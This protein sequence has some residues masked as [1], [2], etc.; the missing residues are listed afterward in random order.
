M[1]S[2]ISRRQFL[3]S[4]LAGTAGLGLSASVRAVEAFPPREFTAWGWPK[5]GYAQIS[6]KSKDWL[7]YKGWWPLQVAWNP[8]WSDNNTILFTM[9][10]RK[11]LEARGLEVAYQ[12]LLAAGVMN[13]AFIPARIQVAQAGSLGLLRLIDLGVPTAAVACNPA[14]RD[15]YLAHPDSPLKHGFEELK[16]QRVLGRPAVIGVT[17]GSLPHMGVLIAA[18]VHGL[19]AGR[20]FTLLNMMPG[21]ILTL[22]KGVDI[23][24]IWEPQVSRMLDEL[25]NA[26]VWSLE[27]PY[28][29]FNG[30]SYLRG[31]IAEEAP[32]VAQAYV[33]AFI[34]ARLMVRA[35]PGPAIDAFA[36]DVTQRGRS[37]AAVTHDIMTYT[38]NPK[39]T[40]SYPFLDT[41]G[42]WA[43]VE[44]YQSGVMAEAGVLKRRYSPEDFKAV[45]RPEFMSGTFSKLGWAVPKRPVFLPEGWTGQVGHPPYPPYGIWNAGKQPFPQAGDL[46]RPWVFQ[47]RRYLPQG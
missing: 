35:A 33:D 36:A 26:R 11:L 28:V 6:E 15:A 25:K 24:G 10:E 20:D 41:D 47:G 38:V 21:D 9:R 1:P 12:P 13:E 29:F 18:K 45:L 8:G 7:K 5:N 19:K 42:V 40:L 23:V 22:P 16:D 44:A 14:Q 32:D 46:V 27:A 17:F 39:P 43:H 3:L 30:Y 34:E 4:S 37:Q 31:E 2:T